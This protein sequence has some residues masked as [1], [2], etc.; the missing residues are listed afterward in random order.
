MDGFGES[1]GIE[2]GPSEN[3]VSSSSILQQFHL[4]SSKFYNEMLPC[5]DN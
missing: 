5:I 3:P 4:I 1:R 2:R